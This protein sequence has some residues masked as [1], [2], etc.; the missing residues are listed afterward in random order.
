MKD[1]VSRTC[2]ECQGRMSPIIVMDK[3]HPT[4]TK[5]RY[6]GSIEYRL[7]DDRLSFWTGKY[8]TSPGSIGRI[9]RRSSSP[10]IRPLIGISVWRST[11]WAACM[12]RRPATTGSSTAP[13]ACAGLQTAAKIRPDGYTVSFSMAWVINTR[14]PHTTGLELSRSGS[15]TRQRMFL[16]SFH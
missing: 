6:T 16:F 10:A 3:L 11:R 7:P 12:T 2:V 15:A 4:P 14:W 9:E 5:H 8:P 1:E 13:L